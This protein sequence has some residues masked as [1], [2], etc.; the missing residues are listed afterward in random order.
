MG[1]KMIYLFFDFYHLFFWKMG[2]KKMDP[3]DPS[4]PQETSE[5]RVTH[6]SCC[7]A[8]LGSALWQAFTNSSSMG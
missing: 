6:H 4:I 2:K 5:E 8:E 7:P 3:Q 1:E